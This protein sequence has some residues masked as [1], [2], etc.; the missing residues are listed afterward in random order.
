MEVTAVEAGNYQA[1]ARKDGRFWLVEIP[2]LAITGQAR[3]LREVD[4]VAREVAGLALDAD[5]DTV[6]VEV[7]FELPGDLAAAWANASAAS[8]AARQAQSSAARR[9]REVV[10]ALRSAGYTYAEAAR[11]LGLS[12]QR[13]HKI[14]ASVGA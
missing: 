10:A 4:E 5:P 3:S 7:D 2:A 1:K 6:R 13:V 14:A 8:A 12:P 9:S 11:V